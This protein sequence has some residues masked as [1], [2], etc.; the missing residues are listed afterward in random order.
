MIVGLDCSRIGQT[1]KERNYVMVSS[2]DEHCSKYYTTI[3]RGEDTGIAPVGSMLTNSLKQFYNNRKFLPLYIF[4]YR[5]GSS[6]REKELILEMEVKQIVDLLS[7]TNSDFLKDYKPKLCFIIVNK[8]IE[9]KFFENNNNSGFDNPRGGTVI[10]TTVVNPNIYEFYIQP[11]YVNM[12]TATPTN[13]HVIYDNTK[14]PCEYLQELTYQLCFYYFNWNGPIRIPAP[15][16]YAEVCNKFATANLTSSVDEDRL[17][18]SAY[19]I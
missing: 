7:G 18:L 3:E 4:I 17:K 19:Y 16:K 6:E 15:L 5:S 13:F 14:V 11:Q 12:G 10:D 2:Y 8:K 1:R 9:L